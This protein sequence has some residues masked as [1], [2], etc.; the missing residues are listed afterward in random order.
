MA[1]CLNKTIERHISDRTVLDDFAEDFAHIVEKHCKYI[2]VSGFVAIAHDRTRAT[3]D[4]DMILEPISKTQFLPLHHEILEA[5]FSCIQTDDGERAYDDYLSKG[6]SIRYTRDPHFAPPEMKVKFAK[7]ELD[8][9]QL[10]TRKKLPSTG[11]DIWFSNIEMNIAFKEELSGSKK[12]WEDAKHLRI[13]Y[14]DEISEEDIVR[15]KEKIRL[16]R[17]KQ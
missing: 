12:D 17:L 16:L 2:I 11:L 9:L 1:A 4:I 6:I 13:V 14:K 7:D 15:I 3:E 8:E 5:G 10:E